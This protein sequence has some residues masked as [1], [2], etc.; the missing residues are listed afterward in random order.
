MLAPV[1]TGKTLVLTERL[2][3][4]ISRG[5]PA[6]KILC[7]TFT[8]RAAREMRD[9]VAERYPEV[10]D[11]VTI[12]TF[13]GLCADMLKIEARSIGL[14]KDF[15]IYDDA[16]CVE[17]VRDIFELGNDVRAA[18]QI[19]SKISDCKSK[20]QQRLL[21]LNC[22]PEELFG[23]LQVNVTDPRS[24]A[25]QYQR[26]LQQRHA[27]DFAD[28]IFLARAMLAERQD[29]RQRWEKRFDLIQ[30]D[31][32]QDTHLSE[33]EI[34]RCLAQGSGNLAMIGDLDQTIY[35]WRGSE[36]DKVIA[37]FTQDFNPKTFHLELNYR[38][39]KTLLKAAS[40]VANTFQTR[41]TSCKPAETCE[42]GEPVSIY[43]APNEQEEGRWIA[44]QI[45]K[46]AGNNGDFAYNRTAILTRTNRRSI[47]ISQILEDQ[48]IPNV[49]VEEYEFFRRPEIKNALAYL[50]FLLNPFDTGSVI[51]ILLSPPRSIGLTTIN[52]I[53]NRGAA[54]GL[55]LVDLVSVQALEAGDPYGYLLDAYQSG[56]IVVFDV[57]TTG[58]SVYQDEII[59]LAATRLVAGSP[60]KTFH[61]YIRNT[62]DVGIS[63]K[64]HGLTNEVL[65]KN[66][67][68]AE[69]V[70]REFFAFAGRAVLV[71]HNLGQF[72]IRIL[73]AHAHR[74]GLKM[75][76]FAWVD[77]LGMSRRFIQVANY[78]LETLA[79]HLHLSIPSHR[80][81]DDVTTTV[82]LLKY[83]VHLA[84]SKADRRRAI[85]DKHGTA[86]SDLAE[87]VK[88]WRLA[89]TERRPADL[90]AQ[91]IAESR[92]YDYYHQE[93]RRQLYL[94]ELVQ[95]FR[96]K[97]DPASPPEAALRSIVEFTALAKNIDHL[98]KNDNRVPVI[99]IHQ[100]KGLEFD[101]VF[102]A[103]A[104]ENE[105][106]N[107]YCVQAGNIEE[108]RRLFY[109]ALTRARKRAAISAFLIDNR[110]NDRSPSRFIEA[111][112]RHYIRQDDE[113]FIQI[114]NLTRQDNDMTDNL[115]VTVTLN[116]NDWQDVRTALRFGCQQL[117]A[118]WLHWAQG[119]S[120]AIQAAI[121]EPDY[122]K[123]D[124]ERW[125]FIFAYEMLWEE[126][127]M[128]EEVYYLV[129]PE[130]EFED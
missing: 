117:D 2:V 8:N 75:P 35:S 33:Y 85:M 65:A 99:T 5:I 72:D 125:D 46:L 54:C 34:V 115:Y 11:R 42:R 18:Q 74:S 40:S 48:N 118:G 93:P 56:E 82:E 71:G 28:L 79:S 66:G 87:Q 21:R 57:E 22:P 111:I 32:V 4:A 20:A 64:L 17:L 19:Y 96:D 92:L 31:E 101:T 130:Y 3:R 77:T 97:D 43:E 16:D 1:G 25:S 49:T 80:A 60:E 61:A 122:W 13:H 108:D 83:L 36:P 113:G 70:F 73:N 121:G 102:I 30:V 24:R 63:E 26:D 90:L 10:A 84:Q 39:T 98:S 15:V 12:R 89:M 7:V 53:M 50:R 124:E 123:Y 59:Q 78:R 14:P 106:P 52:E 9:R 104:V 119:I 105:F 51:R 120:L 38:S 81:D 62:I 100:A 110:S 41:Y 88:T 76:D 129:E 103:G 44:H 67:R 126:Y 27:L 6:N 107:Y 23:P 68:P 47:Q 127:P 116:K 91:V 45:R 29:I 69:E 37:Q 86:F 55:R 95:I 94:T 128:M 109:V 112:D 114:K 58:T